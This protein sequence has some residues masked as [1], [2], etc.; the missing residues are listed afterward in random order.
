V[1]TRTSRPYQGQVRT[2]AQGELRETGGAPATPSE[3]GRV[4]AVA[5]ARSALSR[6]Q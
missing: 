1:L 4:T 6:P 3:G 2:G 5:G